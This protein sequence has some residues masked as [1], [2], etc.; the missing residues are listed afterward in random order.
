MSRFVACL[1]GIYISAAGFAR[2]FFRELSQICRVGLASGSGDF[3]NI[4][5]VMKMTY[6]AMLIPFIIIRSNMD[7]YRMLKSGLGQHITNM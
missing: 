6:S 7:W 4:R 1:R 2:D 3:G 5:Y